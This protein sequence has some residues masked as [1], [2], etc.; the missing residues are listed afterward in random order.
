M[1]IRPMRHACGELLHVEIFISHGDV[2]PAF[3]SK[4][5]RNAEGNPIHEC[6][7]GCGYPLDLDWCGHPYLIDPMSD[8]AIENVIKNKH[9]SNCWGYE[10]EQRTIFDDGGEVVGQIV[11][12]SLCQEETIGFVSNNFIRAQRTEDYINYSRTAVDISKA[13][14]IEPPEFRS[15]EENLKELGF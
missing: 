2:I 10:F 7:K 13:L 11:V 1:K 14:G 3:F 5:D 12:C 15:E 8:Q 4:F 6:P 9:C